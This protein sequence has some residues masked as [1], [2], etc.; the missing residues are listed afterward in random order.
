MMDDLHGRRSEPNL[1]LLLKVLGFIFLLMATGRSNL[2]LGKHAMAMCSI[3]TPEHVRSQEN[4]RS[5]TD[6]QH[7]G[8][9]YLKLYPVLDKSKEKKLTSILHSF[10]VFLIY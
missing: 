7:T 4:A 3:D 2:P 9:G 5:A 10:Q 8:V 1:T 6:A